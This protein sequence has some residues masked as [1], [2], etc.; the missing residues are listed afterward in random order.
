MSRE[1]FTHFWRRY[2]AKMIYALRP[3][4]FC[5]WNSAD[6][7]VLTFCVSGLCVAIES[8]PLFLLPNFKMYLSYVQYFLSKSKNVFVALGIDKSIDWRAFK[9]QWYLAH[10][11]NCKVFLQN[12]STKCIFLIKKYICCTLSID[13]RTSALQWDLPQLSPRDWQLSAPVKGFEAWLVASTA[14]PAPAVALLPKN[15]QSK[16]F[17]KD[18]QRQ[19]PIGRREVESSL[20]VSRWSWFQILKKPQVTSW[21]LPLTWI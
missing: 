11:E 15:L 4:S 12:F 19:Q 17:C 8:P 6:R 20:G 14:P 7:K 5:P 18:L 10:S 3:E 2:V 13:W 16:L 21:L 1:R 9:L